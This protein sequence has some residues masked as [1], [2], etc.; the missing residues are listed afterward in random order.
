MELVI[1]FITRRVSIINIRKAELSYRLERIIEG[2]N[3]RIST[4]IV[5]IVDRRVVLHHISPFVPTDQ[6]QH[7]S[8]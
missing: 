2:Y 8:R 4:V 6:L 7:F 3:L 5:C 1:R